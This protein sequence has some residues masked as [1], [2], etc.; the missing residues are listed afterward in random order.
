M[1]GSNGILCRHHQQECVRLSMHE[2]RK[3]LVASELAIS[4]RSYSDITDAL[5]ECI[6]TDGFILTEKDVAPEFFDLRTG[7]AG[8]LFQ[9][10][11]RENVRQVLV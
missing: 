2:E 8:E 7:L 9:K 4:I 10:F 1:C 3:I 5:G 6:G 11:I